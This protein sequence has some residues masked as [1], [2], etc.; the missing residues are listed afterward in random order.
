MCLP[1]FV[2]KQGRFSVAEST[3]YFINIVKDFAELEKYQKKILEEAEKPYPSVVVIQNIDK[4]QVGD[5]Y[6]LFD[7]NIIPTRD[8]F[9]AL[10]LTFKV[11]ATFKIPYPHASAVLWTLVQKVIYKIENCGPNKSLS[12]IGQLLLIFS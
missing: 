10:D 11:F 2:G 7:E 6:V 8:I 5:V 4:S 3:N 9:E 12:S 1:G